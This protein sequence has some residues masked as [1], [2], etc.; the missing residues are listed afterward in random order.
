[1]TKTAQLRVYS[2]TATPSADP[3]PGF[4]R[5]FGML[6]ESIDRD[7]TAEWEGKV[8]VCPA[9]LR[10]RVLESTVAFANA[11]TGLGASIIPERAARVAIDELRRY[12]A[13][14]PEHRSHVLT[15]AWHVPIRWFTL[16]QPSD[17]DIYEGPGGPR[18][19]FR[20]SL[21]EAMHRLLRSTRILEASGMFR[22]PVDDMV[23]LYEWLEPFPEGS[24]VELDYGGVAEL[25]DPADVV[26][27]DTCELINESL[28]ALAEGDMVRAGECYGR[29]VSRWAPAFSVTFSN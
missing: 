2:P 16:F 1:M 10:L 19:R 14:H 22:G 4:V 3:V 24:M 23:H 13:D 12:H 27:D 25:F 26:L 11:F 15:A 17:R 20:A 29:V 21:S 5:D 9:H 28:D 7:V 18:V 8:V 6:S